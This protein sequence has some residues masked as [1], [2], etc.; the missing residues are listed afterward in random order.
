VTGIITC[1]FNSALA[2]IGE[3]VNG[4]EIVMVSHGLAHE[5]FQSRTQF[6]LC[7][8]AINTKC[9]SLCGR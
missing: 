8:A 5:V 6:L 1:L 7:D 3:H 4:V 2:Y 9:I